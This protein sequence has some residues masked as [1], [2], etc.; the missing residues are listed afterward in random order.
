MIIHG[1]LT[2]NM[3]RCGSAERLR[4]NSPRGSK[5][6]IAND[7]LATNHIQALAFPDHIV[8]GGLVSRFSLEL[9]SCAEPMGQH[10]GLRA[11]VE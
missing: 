4:R 1:E 11:T 7:G 8:S 10:H 9:S 5:K 3:V 2:S 6:M